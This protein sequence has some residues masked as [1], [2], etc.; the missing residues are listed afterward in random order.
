MSLRLSSDVFEPNQLIPRR[1]TKDG[2]NI[3][4]ALSWQG[5]PVRT[6]SFALLVE[7]PDAPRGVFTH[8]VCFNIPAETQGMPPG[9]PK[10][11]AFGEGLIQGKTILAGWAT[12]APNLRRGHHITITLPSTRWIPDF[13]CAK[14]PLN[15]RC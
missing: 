2:E 5:E 13:P 15:R 7:D 4:P 10:R 11:G 3:S 14:G 6:A 1:F 8:W 12:M 9:I